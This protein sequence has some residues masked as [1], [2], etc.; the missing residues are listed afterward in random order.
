[1]GLTACC[2]FTKS[3]GEAFPYIAL[4]PSDRCAFGRE[5]G[6][7]GWGRTPWPDPAVPD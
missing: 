4:K 2:S 1:M 5:N 6:V 7:A 3:I